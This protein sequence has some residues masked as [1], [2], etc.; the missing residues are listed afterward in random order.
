MVRV[1]EKME[2]G[3]C[4][5]SRGRSGLD[6]FGLERKRIVDVSVGLDAGLISG[7]V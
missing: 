2:E 4:S 5:S 7:Q 6:P 1:L 3:H